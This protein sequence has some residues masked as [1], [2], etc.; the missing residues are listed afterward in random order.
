MVE[1]EGREGERLAA[2]PPTLVPPTSGTLR[3]SRGGSSR[4]GGGRRG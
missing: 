2:V 1:V 4:K 3:G